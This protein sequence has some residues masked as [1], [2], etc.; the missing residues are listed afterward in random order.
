MP[1]QGGP[2]QPVVV[3]SSGPVAGGPAIPVQAMTDVTAD[4]AIQG[5][6]VIAVYDATAEVTAGTRRV[7]GGPAIP[8]AV[9]TGGGGAVGG[10]AI[11]V[12][13]V[14]GSFVTAVAPVNT[15]LPVISGTP[16]PG[17]TLS[18]SN[19]T[20]A[21]TPTSYAYQWKR[22]GVAI[23]GATGS[24]YAVQSADSGTTLTVTVTAS[25]AGGS[26][27]A[28]SAGLAISSLFSS[29]VAY[30]KLDEASGTRYDAT[31]RGNDLPLL[32]TPGTAPA[33]IN[34]GTS[35]VAA[36]SQSLGPSATTGDLSMGDIDFTIAGWV[37]L[38]SKSTVRSIF[39]KWSGATS[40]NQEYGADYDNASDR[41]RFYIKG[42]SLVVSATTFGSPSL[43]TWYF[44][45]CQHD[46]VNNVI[47]ISV[48][49]G[50]FNTTATGGQFPAA[51]IETL[52]FGSQKG[53]SV[54]VSWD[55]RLWNWGVW[56]RLLTASEIAAFYNSGNG[57]LLPLTA[58]GA[59]VRYGSSP[60]L[61]KGAPG[62]WEETDVANPDVKWDAPN[63][64]WVMN[65]SGYSVTANKWKLGLAYSTDLINWTK[66]PTNPVFS[67]SVSE[68]YIC[69]NGSIVYKNGTYYHYY[70]AGDFLT[71]CATSPDLLTWT[72][73][74][75]G[76]PVLPKG[77]T[78]AIDD[79]Q[80]ADPMARIR[81]DGVIEIYYIAR[82]SVSAACYAKATSSDGITFTKLGKIADQPSIGASN[83]GEPFAF[84]FDE[85]GYR[86]THDAASTTNTRFIIEQFSVDGGATFRV[87][88][89]AL[90]GS[91]SGW[92][93]VQV[94]DSCVVLAFGQTYLFYAGAPAPGPAENMG[95]QI[96]L[97]IA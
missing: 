69:S 53:S 61:A 76:A 8:M 29:L 58:R 2:A 52:G 25:N 44:I 96:G 67:P 3:A 74:N 43:N 35:F 73:Q 19:G 88:G 82:S 33:P 42:F 50:A 16:A 93:S 83:A 70:N 41:F 89:I 64:R 36:S 47:K 86:F 85:I 90:A 68:G 37:Y 14:S 81:D 18:A 22:D 51:G 45:V 30:W 80:T 32:G 1:T 21:N 49:G 97:A 17:Q 91:G 65:Y 95:A 63:N 12:Y 15:G 34:N 5:G 62:S 84:A 48:N 20:W 56:R 28:T 54:V 39:D 59:F 94:F 71:Y 31:M 92:D 66:E 24:T 10:P 7:Q 9:R 23:S 72:R 4:R 57:M 75:G 11:P 40:A 27:S 6:P 79:I 55:G 87:R 77:A 38:A 13:V 78:G 26:A 46:A 60:I